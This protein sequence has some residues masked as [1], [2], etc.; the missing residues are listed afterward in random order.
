MPVNENNQKINSL[1][2]KIA[3][4]L[5][6]TSDQMLKLS[7][8]I[9][10]VLNP[11]SVNDSSESIQEQKSKF[12][13][14]PPKPIK[15]QKPEEFNITKEIAA[16]QLDKSPPEVILI[17]KESM[18][19]ITNQMH[20]LLEKLKTKVISNAPPE[21]EQ[22]LDAPDDLTS[23][24]EK[25]NDVY[26]KFKSFMSEDELQEMKPEERKQALKDMADAIRILTEEYYK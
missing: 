20:G 25:M 1:L 19:T 5:K 8:E 15:I 21:V 26:R 18:E 12:P 3:D 16:N 2:M 22:K 11:D 23:F 9:Q 14:G 6:T 4:I 24:R 13:P 10:V 7:Q 17:E